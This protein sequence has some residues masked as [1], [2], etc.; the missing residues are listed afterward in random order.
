L[1]VALIIRGQTLLAFVVIALMT[2]IKFYPIVLFGLIL[3]KLKKRWVLFVALGLISL[4]SLQIFYDISKGPGFINIFWASFGSPIWGIYAGYIGIHIN[5]G[6]SI[7]LG[8]CIFLISLFI[9]NRLL[10][11]GES[12]LPKEQIFDSKGVE[13]LFTYASTIFLFCYL[14]GMNFDY[15]LVFFLICNLMLIF[16]SN[17]ST[18]LIMILK[19]LLIPAFWFSYNLHELQPIGDLSLA[20]LAAINTLVL[21]RVLLN[22]NSGNYL[23]KRFRS[24]FINF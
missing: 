7:I 12:S 6:L 4:V 5:Y 13:T 14:L 8:A 2:L 10:K 15:R 24:N 23:V 16:A 22:Q 1:L 20:F 11:R 18:Q 19:V 21:F 3:I 17:L 9:V